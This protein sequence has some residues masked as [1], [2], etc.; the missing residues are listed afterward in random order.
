MEKNRI[1]DLVTGLSGARGGGGG[2]TGRVG[3]GQTVDRPYTSRRV[4]T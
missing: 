1:V 3:L 2:H 4:P